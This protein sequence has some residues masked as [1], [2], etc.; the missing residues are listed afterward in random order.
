MPKFQKN[1]IKDL[2]ELLHNSYVH[3]SNLE[4]FEYNC[5]NDNIKIELLNPNFNV[6]VD[7]TFI[8]I[9]IA[10]KIKGDWHG[11]SETVVSL[12]VEDDFSYLQNCFL[13]ESKHVEDN[14][15]MLFQMFSGDEM[16]IVS[17]EVIVEIVDWKGR[18]LR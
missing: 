9:E 6:K 14:L 10:L 15:Y 4:N 5:K 16:H 2:E 17:K 18:V 1:N 11:S 13:K 7:L 8:S 3:D 12:T